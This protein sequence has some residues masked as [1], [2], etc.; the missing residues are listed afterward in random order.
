VLEY[1]AALKLDGLDW[2]LIRTSALPLKSFQGRRRYVMAMPSACVD[3]GSCC[4]LRLVSFTI[5]D[6]SVS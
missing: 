5:A 2:E 4:R 6:A 1:V 3:R